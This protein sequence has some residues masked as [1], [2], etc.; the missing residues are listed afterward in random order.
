VLVTDACGS[1]DKEAAKRSIETLKFAGD[2]LITDT[3]TIC[4]VLRARSGSRVSQI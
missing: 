4:N 2:T 1:G 3:E